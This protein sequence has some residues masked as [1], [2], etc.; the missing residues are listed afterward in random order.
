MGGPRCSVNLCRM[1]ELSR[2]RF[3]VNTAAWSDRGIDAKDEEDGN[4]ELSCS[5]LF[6]AAD[7]LC[8]TF[9]V[10]AAARTADEGGE[11]DR[12]KTGCSVVRMAIESFCSAVLW[13]GTIWFA[14]GADDGDD[15]PAAAAALLDASATADLAA[16][17][18]SILS[19]FLGEANTES[20][21]CVHANHRT[22]RVHHNP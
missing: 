5:G 7:T 10:G 4:A 22:S 13:V 15:R 2:C 16:P 11:D 3:P 17:S 8:F 6:K 1:T 14:N 20:V 21:V 12:G 19:R 18:W 9:S